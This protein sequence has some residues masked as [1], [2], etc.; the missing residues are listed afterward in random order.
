MQT[1][2]LDLPRMRRERYARLAAEMDR[3]G[4]G[5]ALLII[6]GNVAYAAGA[7]GLMADGDR[8]NYQR[9]VV[10]AVKGQAAPH[11]FTAYPEGAPPELP[12]DHIHPA[13]YPDLEE[14]VRATA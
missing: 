9:T 10:L 7:R 11:L 3:R 6:P 13:L 4:A 2:V 14:G 1:D 12:A 5:A 8:A